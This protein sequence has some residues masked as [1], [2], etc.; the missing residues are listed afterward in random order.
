M[1]VPCLGATEQ[2]P[3]PAPATVDHAESYMGFE[4]F[5]GH[6]AYGQAAREGVGMTTAACSTVTSSKFQQGF[7]KLLD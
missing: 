4:N 7:W 2:P 5:Q 6:G 1:D 3:N